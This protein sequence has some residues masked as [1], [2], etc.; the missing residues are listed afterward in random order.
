[1][2]VMGSR[3]V[4][5]VAVWECTHCKEDFTQVKDTDVPEMTICYGGKGQSHEWRVVDNGTRPER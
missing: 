4:H 2:R 5:N 3:R 1:M